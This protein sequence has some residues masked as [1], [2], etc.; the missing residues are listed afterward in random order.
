M[1][2]RFKFSSFLV[3]PVSMLL[4]STA[5]A[6]QPQARPNEAGSVSPDYLHL[7]KCVADPWTADPE[8]AIGLPQN[9]VT[10]DAY[11]RLG[12]FDGGSDLQLRHLADSLHTAARKKQIADRNGK[13]AK[14]EAKDDLA[15]ANFNTTTKT[16][17]DGMD[18][19]MIRYRTE[20]VQTGA[21]LL[22]H[23]MYAMALRNIEDAATR[24]D[25]ELKAKV[26]DAT[27]ALRSIAPKMY[28]PSPLEQTMLTPSI[29]PEGIS[30][31]N[32][33][34]HVLTN[35]T[36]TV[37]LVHFCTAPDP[38]AYRVL[39]TPRL[40]PGKK[41]YISPNVGLN[42][43]SDA[44]KAGRYVRPKWA[45]R[46]T[47]DGERWVLNTGGYVEMRIG[48]WAQEGHQADSVIKFPEA[49]KKV[50]EYEMGAVNRV[51]AR[52]ST[53][54]KPDIDAEDDPNRIFILEGARR[55]LHLAPDN[56]VLTSDANAILANP[57]AEAKKQRAILAQMTCDQIGGRYRV[58]YDRGTSIL[59]IDAFPNTG[60]KILASLSDPASPKTK[61]PFTGNI[62][63]V[64]MGERKVELYHVTNYNPSGP[65]LTSYGPRPAGTTRSK[66]GSSTSWSLGTTPHST[67]QGASLLDKG[68]SRSTLKGSTL[69][70][71]KS[72]GRSNSASPFGTPSQPAEPATTGNDGG[73]PLLTAYRIVLEFSDGKANGKATLGRKTAS[74]GFELPLSVSRMEESPEPRTV[75]TPQQ[76]AINLYP[77]LAKPES[78]LN[79]EFL[80]RVKEY[81]QS[82]KSY[83]SDPQWP[84]KLA[85]ESWEAVGKPASR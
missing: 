38:T 9:I 56:P 6:Q 41:I 73:N 69:I 22:D 4:L 79:K 10:S 24:A 33:S 60:K 81:Q 65:G 29:S 68:N 18:R 55:I 47:N 2:Y 34:G 21:G 52:L 30:F 26:T 23:W 44:W 3:L 78:A 76:L 45:N 31:E 85:R 80:R 50:A 19:G 77:D 70:G 39:Y 32:T 35:L 7:L 11:T 74:G 75:M 54:A 16:V 72:S 62:P 83:F 48:A 49:A 13:I 82:Q 84:T 15:G 63:D 42:Y 64:D 8:K 46:A 71:N 57:N 1:K 40:G 53:P 25:N 17:P 5:A 14:Q 67:L 28:A 58:N 12:D 51:L 66:P 27:F 36:L 43:F 61:R 20:E 59:E 37:D